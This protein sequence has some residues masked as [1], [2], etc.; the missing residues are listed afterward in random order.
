MI[1]SGQTIKEEQIISPFHEKTVQ[2]G[3]S[4]GVSHAG[5]DIRISLASDRD[6]MLRQLPQPIKLKPG[7]AR[8]FGSVEKFTMPLDVIGF[9]KDKSTWA[10]RFLACQNTVIEPGWEGYLTIEL[11]NHGSETLEIFHG[12]PIAQVIFNRIDRPV[13]GYKGKYQGQ[14]AGP[15]E[16]RFE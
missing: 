10:R 14:E 2:R 13:E 7:E 3:M 1:L 11:T 4:F 12:D 8:L 16:A 5:Y 15:Q 9:V 6:M